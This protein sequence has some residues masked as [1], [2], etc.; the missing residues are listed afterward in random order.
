MPRVERPHK[1][2]KCIQSNCSIQGLSVQCLVILC[3]AGRKKVNSLTFNLWLSCYQN[4][5]EEE[6]APP[7]YEYCRT[8]VLQ[9]AAA[10]S[11][12]VKKVSLTQCTHFS[13]LLL[14]FLMAM[15]SAKAF[16]FST[17]SCATRCWWVETSPSSCW[18]LH[19]YSGT[20]TRWNHS[21]CVLT[22]ET[23]IKCT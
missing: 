14:S 3:V 2:T 5:K 7:P 9:I 16:S 17:W 21:E 18:I 19:T 22:G 12:A 4:V 1:D 15:R 13:M 23:K 6:S 10:C 11:Q 20:E 8:T